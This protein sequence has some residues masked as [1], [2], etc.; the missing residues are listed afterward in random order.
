MNLPT[1][2]LEQILATRYDPAREDEALEI[3][4]AHP[5]LA[6]EK[7]AGPEGVEGGFI[8]GSTVLHYASNDGKLRLMERLIELGADVNADEAR[9]YATPLAWAA[10]N[11][12]IEALGLL[13]DRGASP[14]SLHALHAVA[15][16][17]SSAGKESPDRYV[18]AVR[19]LIARGA[20]PGDTREPGRRTP[21]EIAIEVGNSAVTDFLKSL[22]SGG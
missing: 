1:S 16:G 11:A 17:G 22:E 9:W 14:R 20:D 12:R 2:P 8:P 13:L 18:E 5:G 4:E 6:T 7:W 15:F 19:L 10:N 3:L 21:L